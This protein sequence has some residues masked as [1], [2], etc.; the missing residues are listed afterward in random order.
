[1]TL[2]A[3]YGILDKRH[4]KVHLNLGLTLPTA[5]VEEKQ[6]GVFLPYG[7]QLGTG[8]F[9]LNLGV[10]YLASYE[11]FSWGAQTIKGLALEDENDTGFRHG[12]TFQFTT[13]IAAPVTQSLSVSARLSYRYQDDIKGHYHGAHNH[14]APQHFQ[15]NYGGH[16][17]ELGLGSNYQF[18]SGLV[19][20]HRLAVEVL[21]P[22]LQD[23]NGVGMDQDLSVVAGW[24]WAF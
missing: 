17:V 15:P 10:T 3:L 8:V 11:H 9:G 19:K 13:W 18:Q 14:S 20:G 22:L 23:A 2:S 7:M 4:H 24:Q 12:D 16:I 5:E 1:V 6:A 21:T